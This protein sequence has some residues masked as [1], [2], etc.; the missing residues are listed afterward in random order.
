MKP[1]IFINAES[2]LWTP[3]DLPVQPWVWYDFSDA[4]T[5]TIT[6]Q[7][8]SEI[9][10]KIGVPTLSLLQGTDS[11]RPTIQ[12]QGG[13]EYANFDGGDTLNRSSITWISGDITF[14][15]VY[16]P[17]ALDNTRIVS[18]NASS[19]LL[20]KF[21]TARGTRFGSDLIGLNLLAN[22]WNVA[23]SDCTSG[24]S[25]TQRHWGNGN[26]FVSSAASNDPAFV[27]NFISIGLGNTGAGVPNYI[28]RLDQV[29]II[30][31]LLSNSDRQKLEGFL[32]WQRVAWNLPANLPTNHPFKNRP[33]YVGD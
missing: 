8:I 31:A 1:S 10:P 17:S 7:G 20:I 15:S 9:R 19:G 21:L 14:V 18:N 29:L 23:I 22:S 11:A 24:V 27:G 26:N 2:R 32:A 12:S 5:R 25:A 28:G 3:R 6:G 16:F 13:I 33:P 4:S 30:P